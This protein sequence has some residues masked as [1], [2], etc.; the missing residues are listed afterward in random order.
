MPSWPVTA[1]VM[2]AW[3]LVLV[4]ESDYRAAAPVIGEANAPNTDR[5]RSIGGDIGSGMSGVMLGDACNRLVDDPTVAPGNEHSSSTPGAF[6]GNLGGA[7][8][9]GQCC[10]KV[11]VLVLAAVVRCCHRF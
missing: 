7:L 2:T 4:P 3:R 6:P 9:R 8:H 5:R 10:S 1:A 11:V